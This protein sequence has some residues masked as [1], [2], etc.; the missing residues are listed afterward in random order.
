MVKELT[1]LRDEAERLLET[2]TIHKDSD[3]P[4]MRRKAHLDLDRFLMQHREEAALLMLDS[5]NTE[6]KVMIDKTKPIK[7]VH[8]LSRIMFALRGKS[9]EPE[10]INKQYEEPVVYELE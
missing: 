6:I 4:N 8:L 3:D 9:P 7:K 1:K 10:R 2:Y 5:L